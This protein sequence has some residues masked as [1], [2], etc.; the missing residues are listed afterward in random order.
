MGNKTTN[1]NP[2]Q[3]VVQHGAPVLVNVFSTNG[4]D[5]S[6]GM[7]IRDEIR[8]MAN[9]LPRAGFYLLKFHIHNTVA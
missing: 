9:S 1:E 6:I 4:S 3:I 2:R 5:H 8:T 7:I